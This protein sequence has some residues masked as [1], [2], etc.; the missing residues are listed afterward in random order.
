MA[1]SLLSIKT[2]KKPKVSKS[3]IYLVNH[4][5]LGDEP[6]KTEKLSDTLKAFN[7]YNSMCTKEDARQY[8]KE[9]FANHNEPSRVKQISSIPDK[10]LPL[11][12]AWVC[13]MATNNEAMLDLNA[14]TRVCNSISEAAAHANDKDDEDDKPAVVRPTIQQ[15]IKDKVDDII[16]DIEEM[17]DVGAEFSLYD[18]LQKRQVPPMHASKISAYYSPVRDEMIEASEGRIEG[19][20]KYTKKWLRDRAAFFG[21]IVEDADRYGSVTKKTRAVRRPRPVSVE[22]QLKG[23]KFQKESAEFKLASIDPQKILGAQ[24]LWT[25]NTKYKSITIFRALDRGGLKVKGTSIASYDENTSASYKTGRKPE[26]IVDQVSKATKAGLKK[27]VDPLKAHTFN[28]RINENT[29]LLKV[30]T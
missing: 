2:K 13:R 25:F 1:K 16:G 8:L 17:I 5:Y 29:I 10:W 19:Y 7:W 26:A 14:Y 6:K 28:P 22:K 24:E 20:E 23:L 21:K 30:I 12:S 11:T 15:R 3:E 18:W 27:V 4:K 9:Y